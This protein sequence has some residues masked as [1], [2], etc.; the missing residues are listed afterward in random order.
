[1]IVEIP[2]SER[3]DILG[4]RHIKTNINIVN[5]NNKLEALRIEYDRS[6]FISPSCL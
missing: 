1:M 2:N 3:F 6:E 5:I 4:I